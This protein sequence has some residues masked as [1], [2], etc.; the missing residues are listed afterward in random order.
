MRLIAARY[1]KRST[2]TSTV[3]WTPSAPPD[4]RASRRML[5][6]PAPVRRGAGS[7]A[8]G[9]APLRRRP[10]A[11]VGT[12]G[13]AQ[14]A[15]RR[16]GAAD[17]AA[18]S[19]PSERGLSRRASS[20]GDS[21][22][23]LPRVADDLL[24]RALRLP[25]QLF[26]D[27][28]DG[29]DEQRRIA[30]PAFGVDGCGLAPGDLGDGFDDLAHRSPQAAAEVVDLVPARR[31]GV[32]RQ[33]VRVSKVEHVDVVADRGAVGRRVVGAEDLAAPRRGRSGCA[34]PAG[35]GGSRWCGARRSVP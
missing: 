4:P 24:E 19:R 15:A 3:R 28:V 14:P 7:E 17:D 16:R 29:G 1:S 26:G 25:R 27:F 22:A 12:A 21:L 2:S 18:S 33:D 8:A 10:G 30:G 5:A 31:Q 11:R 23:E 6:V 20:G 34:A 32:E 35:S 13:R 9:R